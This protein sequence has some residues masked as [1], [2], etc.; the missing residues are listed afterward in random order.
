M[1]ILL[2]DDTATERFIMT[3]HLKNMG[4]EI[5]AGNNGEEAV[6]LCQSEHPDLIL[7]DVIMPV[8]DGHEAAVAI[9]ALDIDWIPIIFLSGRTDPDD[10]VAGIDAGGDDYLTKPV[11]EKVLKAKMIAMQRIAVM[12][13]QLIETTG[14]LEEA[15]AELKLL[16]DVDGL[17]KLANRRHMEAHL[18]RSIRLCSR[19]DHPLSFI[20]IDIDYFKKYNDLYGHL[21]GDSCLKKVAKVLKRELSRPVDLACRYGGE[22]FCLILPD[23]DTDGAS[24][25]AKK[26]QNAVEQLNIPHSENEGKNRV[27]F[28]AGIVTEIPEKNLSMEKLIVKADQ[29]LYQSKDSGRDQVTFYSP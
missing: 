8:M 15:N 16:A 25:V 19:Y 11:N 28:S 23:T 22:E 21:A 27:T 2:V 26:I 24:F 12:R 29:A 5:I 9:R 13:R 17:T 1:K 20:L 18:K 14:K 3:A 10:I 4:H 7:M 6:D